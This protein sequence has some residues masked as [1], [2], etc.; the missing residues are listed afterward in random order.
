M[1]NTLALFI[2]AFIGLSCSTNPCKMSAK[3]FEVKGAYFGKVHIEANDACPA[4]ITIEGA[5]SKSSLIEFR[6][7]YP[8]NLDRKFKKD[9]CCIRFNY[10]LSRAMSPEG[11]STDA[12]VSLE[13]VE[14][15]KKNEGFKF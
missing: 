2:T 11:C 7:I 5:Y 1:K 13:Q 8:I 9:G 3:E 14:K 10:T 6:S 4:Y 12:V 15:A